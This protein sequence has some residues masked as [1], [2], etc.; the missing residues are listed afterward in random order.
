[1]ILRKEK[2]TMKKRIE[3]RIQEL[4]A[5]NFTASEIARTLKAEGYRNRNGR[6]YSKNYVYVI[7]RRRTT[8]ASETTEN[9]TPQVSLYTPPQSTRGNVAVIFCDINDLQTVL[10]TAA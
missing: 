1:L 5:K 10:K 8:V 9:T 6:A 3:D 2:P 7:A 4:R